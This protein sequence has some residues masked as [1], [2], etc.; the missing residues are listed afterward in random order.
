MAKA[1]YF[2]VITSFVGTLEGREVE[3]HVGEVVSA[4]DPA[5]KKMPQHFAPLIVRAI[6]GK[7]VEQAT[8]APGEKRSR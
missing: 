8:A 3:Y 5:L 7:P 2:T 1:D 4:E 6:P